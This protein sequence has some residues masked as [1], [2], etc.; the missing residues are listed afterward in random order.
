MR[1]LALIVLLACVAAT[2]VS[3]PARLE[4]DNDGGSQWMAAFSVS[5]PLGG[6]MHLARGSA[7]TLTQRF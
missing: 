2:E 5:N 3:L 7:A 6:A 1:A 4:L